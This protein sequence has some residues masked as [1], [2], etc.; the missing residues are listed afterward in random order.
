MARWRAGRRIG[1][2]SAEAL[3]DAAAVV[4]DA[5]RV[6]TV[7]LTETLRELGDL[8]AEVRGFEL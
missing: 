2:G 5:A 3:A 1:Q 6:I 8:E 4:D 7:D